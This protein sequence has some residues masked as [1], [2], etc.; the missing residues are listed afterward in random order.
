[1]DYKKRWPSTPCARFNFLPPFL[2]SH[3]FGDPHCISP[4]LY[5]TPRVLWVG[6]G[7]PPILVAPPGHSAFPG[8]RFFSQNFPFFLA[9]K[10]P[11]E[12]AGAVPWW[13]ASLTVLCS[14]AAA[15]WPRGGEARA[16]GGQGGAGRH[17]ADGHQDAQGA[18]QA[19][20]AHQAH[21]R[22]GRHPDADAPRPCPTQG[23]THR[24]RLGIR[25]RGIGG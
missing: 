20:G 3:A 6:G 15:V 19:A 9:L 1:M 18:R 24:R 22:R 10:A 8:R 4:G 17:H 2:S 21:L 14:V 25:G 16:G 12:F 23:P 11:T 13:G 7:P 5:G